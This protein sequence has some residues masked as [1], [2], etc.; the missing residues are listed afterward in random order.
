M[1]DDF[2]T[3]KNCDRC[4]CSLMGKSRKMSRFNE[5]CLCGDCAEDERNNPRYKEAVEAEM[6]EIRKGNYNFKGIGL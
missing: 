5:D 2:F 4:G 1:S 6:E 3:K